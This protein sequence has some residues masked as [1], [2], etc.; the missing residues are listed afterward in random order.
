MD[1]GIIEILDGLCY[2]G[3]LVSDSGRGGV[4]M[5]RSYVWF[6]WVVFLVLGY[7]G[8]VEKLYSRF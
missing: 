8:E 6:W 7:M 3:F 4:R 5:F 1:R 2:F